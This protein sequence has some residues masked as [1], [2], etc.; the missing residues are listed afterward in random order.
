MKTF[1]PLIFLLTINVFAA[2]VHCF[3]EICIN[4]FVRDSYGWGGEVA[5]I[6]ESGTL[7]VALFHEP[8]FL[9]KFEYAEVGKAV[10]CHKSFCIGNIVIDPYGN[11]ATIQE[12]YT[13]D[14]VI[15]IYPDDFDDDQIYVYK[16]EQIQMP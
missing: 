13:N 5:R 15:L 2:D 9:A 4:D 16:L 6:E 3:K 1:L 8:G 12:I 10:K 11:S 14:I 7:H